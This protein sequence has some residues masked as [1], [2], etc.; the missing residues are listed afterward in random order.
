MA[1]THL[2]PRPVRT[3]PQGRAIPPSRAAA[4]RRPL[5]ERRPA[6]P[7]PGRTPGQ[8]G[9][10]LWV[11]LDPSDTSPHAAEIIELAE[12]LGEL[13][14]ELLPTAETFTALSLGSPEGAA[15]APADLGALRT[16]L[17]ELEVVTHTR[18]A[19]D[20]PARPV[21][22]FDIDLSPR[23]VIDV[24]ARQVLVD[25]SE[26]HMTYKEFELLAHL[27]TSSGRVVPRTELLGSV[28]RGGTLDSG[29]RT[30]D[31]HVRRLRDKLGLHDAIIT[32]RGAGYRFEPTGTVSVRLSP[33]GTD[34]HAV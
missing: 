16:R 30:I 15:A 13:A 27:V 9:F 7:I 29:S 1:T 18:W 3:A 17:A 28:W 25:G 11:G 31:V 12:T 10:L 21:P 32:V 2:L 14:R 23:V 5:V 33:V 24:P 6:V 8:A 20:E 22:D 26:Q 34:Q 4:P 19:D